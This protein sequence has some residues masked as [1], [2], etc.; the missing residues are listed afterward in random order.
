MS[1]CLEAL[2]WKEFLPKG[3]NRGGD[4]NKNVRAGKILKNHLFYY[5]YYSFP[6][7]N[8]KNVPTKFLVSDEVLSQRSLLVSIILLFSSDTSR[9]A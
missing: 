6:F 8:I 5:Y 2:S 4:W 3:N 1:I 9:T 7:N